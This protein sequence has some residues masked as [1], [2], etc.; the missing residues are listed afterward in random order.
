MKI[1]LSKSLLTGAA[2]VAM[3]FAACSKNN[4]E[5]TSDS[6]TS[7]RAIL[8][9][10][11]IDTT[12]N[13]TGTSFSYYTAW[14]PQ[15]VTLSGGSGVQVKWEGY[16]N[17]F[18]RP[19]TSNYYIGTVANVDTCD[20]WATIRSKITVKNIT[21]NVGAAPDT[22]GYSKYNV[23]GINGVFS[24]VN[25]GLGYYH[26]VTGV[27]TVDSSIVVWKD[28]RGSGS[29]SYVSNPVTAP[30][31]ADAYVFHVVSYTIGGGG[32]S[33]YTSAV[34]YSYKKI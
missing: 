24:S 3:L 2:A 6:N 19:V 32:P 31:V 12:V 22:V 1:T 23:V 29:V 34:R 30:G 15:T 7:P 13:S 25:Y 28:T 33:P 16:S 26:Y 14:N 4:K 17:S 9:C 27:P 5:T 10:T 11:L 8:A 21:A 18:L 20:S